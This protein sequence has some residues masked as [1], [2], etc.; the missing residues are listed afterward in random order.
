MTTDLAHVK[1][2]AGGMLALLH[3]ESGLSIPIPFSRPIRLIDTFV[4]GTFF[5]K[6]VD[7]LADR[8]REGDRLTL[9]REPDNRYDKYAIVV[10]DPEGNKLG[11]VPRKNNIVLANLMDAGKSVYATLTRKS[12]AYSSV[13]L[14]IG[15]F[16]EE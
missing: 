15:I 8:L 9:L 11:Y 3:G 5:V 6:G 2:S 4:T 7:S 12:T 14:S 1:S 16:M 13:N 10:N